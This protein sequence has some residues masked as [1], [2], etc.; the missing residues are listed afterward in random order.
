MRIKE[1][2]I[3]AGVFDAAVFSGDDVEI[4]SVVTDSRQITDG[5]CFIA[6][7]GYTSDGHD[8][9]ADAVSGGASV[10]V[11]EDDSS[12]PAGF[13]R[14][15]VTDARSCGGPLAQ[16]ILHWPGRKLKIVAITGTN[17]KTTVAYMIR[18]ILTAAGYKTGLI[19]TIEYDTGSGCED[20]VA[21]TPD[22]VALAAM[23]ADMLDMGLTHLVMEV[24]SHALDQARVAGLDF[25]VGIYTNLSG[26]HLDYHE[27]FE[28]YRSAKAKLFSQLG[29]D[30]RA[31]INRDDSEGD[32]MSA[33]APCPTVWYGL[34]LLADVRAK[35]QQIAA[36][37]SAIQVTTSAGEVDMLLPLIGRNNVYNALSAIAACEVLGAT[38]ELSCRA[39]SHMTLVPGRLQ[40]VDSEA[41]FDVFVDYAHTDDA[42]VNVLSSL[43]PVTRGRL[44]LVFG[45]GGDRDRTKRPRM[46]AVAQDLADVL[47]IT[48]DNPRNEE[49]MAIID[50]MLAGLDESGRSRCEVEPD[51]ARAIAKSIFIARSGDVVLIAGK[52]HERFQI[53]GKERIEFDDVATAF[54]MINDQ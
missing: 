2:L 11:C 25:A 48:A 23:M 34:N 13:P 26:D 35:I 40:R 3:S 20:S 45:C 47:I 53:V 17:G 4:S 24:S 10:V 15:V 5:C 36:C 51:R 50:D 30:G 43:R 52:G 7:R 8:Y 32:Y 12:I 21:T 18:E 49:P 37:G 1:L 6:V 19:G 29:P 16:A 44:I 22:G 38:P 33:S 42:L 9:I 14:A 27:T 28:K 31:V 54:S 41:P 46:A 39:L